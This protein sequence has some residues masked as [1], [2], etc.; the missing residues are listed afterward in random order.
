MDVE[1]LWKPRDY[2]RRGVKVERKWKNCR[3]VMLMGWKNSLKISKGVIR[4]R[5]LKENRQHS[6][7]KNY[8]KMTNNDL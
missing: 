5:K 1:E 3:Y 6:G 7:L 4:I 8:D 2:R